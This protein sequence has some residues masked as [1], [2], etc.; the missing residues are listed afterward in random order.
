[1]FTFNKKCLILFSSLF[2]IEILI[3]VFVHD[4]FIRPYMG[5]VLV[6]IL[7][8][9]FLKSL[10]RISMLKAAIAVLIFSFLIETLQFLNIV[11]RIGLGHSKI[12]RIVMG[13]HFAWADIISYTAGFLIIIA[14]EASRQKSL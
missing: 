7:L 13:T 4:N 5:D 9:C 3:A 12:A 10:L 8:Y 2:I 11:D 14:C 6:V 1:M